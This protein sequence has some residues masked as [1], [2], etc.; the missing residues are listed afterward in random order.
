MA[1]LQNKGKLLFGLERA[2]NVHFS[3]LCFFTL[4]FINLST[5]MEGM[6]DQSSKL[7][8]FIYL[9]FSLAIKST[10]VCTAKGFCGSQTLSK[11]RSQKETLMSHHFV[12]HHM[13]MAVLFFFVF[14]GFFFASSLDMSMK[15]HVLIYE[16]K[17]VLNKSSFCVFL[18]TQVHDT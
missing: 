7:L 10:I 11:N 9:F 13:D 14:F 3:E 5:L 15:N 16:L 17:I 8:H 12:T 4:N 1:H 18:C 6:E 2:V